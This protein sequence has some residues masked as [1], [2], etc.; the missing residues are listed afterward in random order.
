M[1]NLKQ[2]TL[3]E[4]RVQL[5]GQAE[6]KEVMRSIRQ[7]LI[8]YGAYVTPHKL[9]CWKRSRAR[10]ANKRNVK[11]PAT[12]RRANSANKRER[13]RVSSAVW[14]NAITVIVTV[15]RV[16]A[17][18]R[19]SVQYRDH[20]QLLRKVMAVTESDCCGPDVSV[21]NCGRRSSPPGT[22]LWREE[23]RTI[24]DQNMTTL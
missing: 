4:L 15:G 19:L 11:Q 23:L 6:V 21:E 18:S 16:V 7:Y 14:G 3:Q 12:Q 1:Y 10:W 13:D 5:M 17:S 8:K 24:K 9:I 2:F 22:K 20:D